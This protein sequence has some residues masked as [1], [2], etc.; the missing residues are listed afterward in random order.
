MKKILLLI[1]AIMALSLGVFAQWTE[2]SYGLR[3]RF[4][5]DQLHQYCK[6]KCCLGN[7]LMMEVVTGATITDFT[8]TT[9][10]GNL[11]TSGNCFNRNYIWTWKHL[12][13]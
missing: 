7:C 11:W 9:N 4:K 2:T 5:R 13:H 1:V 6:P 12:C 3:N 10:G 8:R